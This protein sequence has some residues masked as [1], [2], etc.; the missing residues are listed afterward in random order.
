MFYHHH[1]RWRRTCAAVLMT[2]LICI[3]GTPLLA[4]RAYAAWNFPYTELTAGAGIV[5]DADTGAVLFQKNMHEKM[6]P[7]SITKV[8][9]ALVVLEHCDLDEQVTFSH[10]DVYNVDAGSSNAQIE[11]G[12]VLTVRDC[13]YALLLL[14]L[15]HI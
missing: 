11:E 2:L 6:A 13:L 10:D 14:S 12:D 8:L 5:L 4:M 7:A 1:G 9:T 3:L 15:I